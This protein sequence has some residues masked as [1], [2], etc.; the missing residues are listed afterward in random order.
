M[1]T[2][3]ID[4]E[5]PT[6]EQREFGKMM[7]RVRQAKTPQDQI[8]LARL[9][10]DQVNLEIQRAQADAQR[11]GGAIPEYGPGGKLLG[12]K[13]DK[14]VPFTIPPY[15]KRKLDKTK[16]YLSDLE[17]SHF[18]RTTQDKIDAARKNILDKNKPVPAKK[19]EPLSIRDHQYNNMKKNLDA[20]K[21]LYGDYGKVG[22]VPTSKEI[23]DLNGMFGSVDKKFM[24]EYEAGKRAEANQAKPK[25]KHK[26]AKLKRPRKR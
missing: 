3:V 13:R 18:Q 6:P 8:A 10:V 25:G 5:G 7:D 9:E 19:P 1:A 26:P 14:S 22:K 23:Q 24:Q 16:L 2:P 12:Y 4:D 21:K 15:L 20:Q 17:Q 11:N